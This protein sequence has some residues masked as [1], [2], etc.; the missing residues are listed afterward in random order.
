MASRDVRMG[1]Y[2]D[3]EFI[4]ASFDGAYTSKEENDP[5]ALTIWG[6][7]FD[8]PGA[9]G[10]GDPGDPKIMLI[11]AWRKWLTLHGTPA[12]RMMPG[13][14]P[15]EYQARC[16]K[17]WGVVEHLAD[18]CRRFKADMLIIEAKATG[19]VVEQEIR[20]V[21][22]REPWGVKTVN[23]GRMDK[24]ARVN[25][26][27]DLFTDGMI[28]RPDK[29]WAQMVEDELAQFPKG[30]HDDLVDTTTQAL[31]FLRR[32]GFAART[33]EARVEVDERR[34]PPAPARRLHYL[35]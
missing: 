16:R 32:G 33:V 11:H 2:P 27:I 4:L 10:Q 30:H 13:E 7:W 1:E 6:L 34:F 31:S 25:A 19:L 17:N 14:D 12:P 20:R 21:Y 26:V 23:P 29:E 15:K 3:F 8:N 35:D 22:S 9:P 5:S 28:W 24:T 18:D